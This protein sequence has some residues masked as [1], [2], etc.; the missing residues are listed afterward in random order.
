MDAMTRFDIRILDATATPTLALFDS[1]LGTYNRVYA[2]DSRFSAPLTFVNV[3][4]FY[5][6]HSGESLRKIYSLLQVPR[7][8]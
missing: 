1:F 4:V 8:T 5:N 2:L 7:R 6:G 3:E